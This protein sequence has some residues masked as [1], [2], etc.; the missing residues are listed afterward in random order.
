MTNSNLHAERGVRTSAGPRRRPR[1]WRAWWAKQIIAWHWISAGVALAAMLLFAVTGI[2]LNHAGSISAEPVVAERSATLPAGL[3]ASLEPAARAK[4]VLPSAVATAVEQAVGLN[5]ADRPVEWSDG[6]AYVALPRPGGDA[7]VSIDRASGAIRAETT[8]RGWIS[9][10]NDLHKGRNA[11]T[12]WFW[13]ID[14]VAIACVL[15]S[16]TG[17]LLLQ[18]HAKRR[19]TT[20]PLVATGIVLPVVLAL[21]LIH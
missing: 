18:L 14:V 6:E 2:T 11:G 21:F 8:D 16:I 15:F 4:A 3:T 19:P 12:A 20:W 7:W 10:L 5:V 1:N 17:L 9:Y 13:F